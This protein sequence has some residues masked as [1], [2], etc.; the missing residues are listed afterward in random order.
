MRTPRHQVPASD[1]DV[2]LPDNSGAGQVMG[3][4][5]ASNILDFEEDEDEVEE[6]PSALMASNFLLNIKRDV[7][8][9][10]L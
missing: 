6:C 8:G 3:K 10:A 1:F 7:F 5:V 4:R 2:R 9:E